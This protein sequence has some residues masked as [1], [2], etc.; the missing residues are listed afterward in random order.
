MPKPSSKKKMMSLT[1]IRSPQD[2]EA[3]E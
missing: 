2:H 1:T 3:S